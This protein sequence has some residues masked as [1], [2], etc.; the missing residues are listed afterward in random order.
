M[1][2]KHEDTKASPEIVTSAFKDE[3]KLTPQ[4][5]LKENAKRNWQ[6]MLHSSVC[7]FEFKCSLAIRLGSRER[8]HHPLHPHV[9]AQQCT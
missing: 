5:N 3:D 8:K 9:E 1:Q 6:T 7:S 2:T 4:Y